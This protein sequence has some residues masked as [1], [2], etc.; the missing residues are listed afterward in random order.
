[1]LGLVAMEKVKVETVGGQEQSQHETVE[2]W[3]SPDLVVYAF[4]LLFLTSFGCVWMHIQVIV[5]FM[6]IDA[7]K[8]LTVG[9]F[10]AHIFTSFSHPV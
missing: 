9:M 1:M 8:L 3:G 6:L 2:G 10:L 7:K 5:T 4:H